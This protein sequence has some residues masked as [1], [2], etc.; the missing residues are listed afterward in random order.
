MVS[1]TNH[2]NAISIDRLSSKTKIGKYSWYFNNSLLCKPEVSSATK[3]FLFLLKTLTKKKY[4][5][6]GPLHL[7]V[8]V[9]DQHFS[10]C[11]YVINRTC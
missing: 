5:C 3:S 9:A 2:Y 10:N 4:S 7:K 11:F 8:E 6:S 1:F